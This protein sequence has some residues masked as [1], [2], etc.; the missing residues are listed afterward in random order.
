MF[1]HSVYF[2]V[3]AGTPTA[4]VDQLEEDCQELLSKI[5]SVKQLWAGRPA[6][7]PRG[8]GG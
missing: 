1:V 8:G 5:P 3:K 4:A 6:M 7:T 2:W